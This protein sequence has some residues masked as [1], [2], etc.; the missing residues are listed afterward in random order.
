MSE[1]KLT[2]RSAN[3]NLTKEICFG[4]GTEAWVSIPL[5]AGGSNCA[6]GCANLPSGVDALDSNRRSHSTLPRISEQ[7]SEMLEPPLRIRCTE[8]QVSP[9]WGALFTLLV[10]NGG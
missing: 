6:L 4:N 2:C 10:N 7:V 9:A 3:G 1:Q 8:G 5:T